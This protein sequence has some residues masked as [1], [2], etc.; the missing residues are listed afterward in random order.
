MISMS[1]PIVSVRNPPASTTALRRNMPNA[2]ET[3][4]RQFMADIAT[5]P[6]RNA[7][8]YSTTWNRASQAVGSLH[9]GNPARIHGAAVADAD[10]PAHGDGGRVL[11]EREHRPHQRQL[12]E[13]RVRVD[14][15]HQVVPRRVD[16]GVDRVGLAAVHL[17]DQHEVRVIE[18]S[19]QAAHRLGGERLLIRDGSTHQAERL[20]GHVERTIRRSVVDHDDFELRVV[21]QQEAAQA[22]RDRGLFAECRHDHRDG[23]G[24]WRAEH[25]VERL[26][27]SS[28]GDAGAARPSPLRR[29]SGRSSS[30]PGN[31]PG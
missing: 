30:A 10:D 3:I 16:A 22:V 5:R 24:G 21:E 23:W 15:A 18:R 17:V 13:Q 29:T 28:A 26:A 7:R 2:P 4:S 12:L 19:V 27:A 25:R 6:P 14:H 9:L 20:D 11:D 1:S 31:R 8:R